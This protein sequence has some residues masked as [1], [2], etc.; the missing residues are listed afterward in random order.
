[1]AEKGIFRKLV[2]SCSYCPIPRWKAEYESIQ[3]QLVPDRANPCVF[4]TG[5]VSMIFDYNMQMRFWSPLEIG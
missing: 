2:P 5:H 4:L 3:M 1:M